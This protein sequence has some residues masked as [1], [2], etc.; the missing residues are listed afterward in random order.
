MQRNG[1]GGHS[2]AAVRG[3]PGRGGVAMKTII[4]DVIAFMLIYV[5][6]WLFWPFR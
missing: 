5:A 4:R 1:L 3:V 2:A 6:L